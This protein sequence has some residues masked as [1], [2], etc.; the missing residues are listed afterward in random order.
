VFIPTKKGQYA[1]RAVYELAR[2]KEQ[3]PIKISAI[4]E[5]QAIPH[6]FLEVILHQLKGSGLVVSKR[7]FYGGYTIVKPPDQ[8]SVGDV[9]RFV[10]KDHMAA[11][12][13][14]CTDQSDCPFAGRCA[15]ASMWRKVFT[16]AFQVYDSISLQ[17]LLDEA[18]AAG[19]PKGAAL[20]MK[21]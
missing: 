8:I 20:E 6:R 5:A 21:P 19:V 18:D 14:A 3:G 1:L 10:H 12:C 2:R 9:L 11:D 4:A 7:G 13:K 16:A 15:F 17:D